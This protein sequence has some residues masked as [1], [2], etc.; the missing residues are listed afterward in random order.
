MFSLLKS[1]PINVRI[2]IP[3][4]LTIK[5]IYSTSTAIDDYH[6]F[7]FFF[8]FLCILI[9]L[10]QKDTNSIFPTISDVPFPVSKIKINYIRNS[11]KTMNIYRTF[12]CYILYFCYI[13]CY[14]Y[15]N[16]NI[17]ST[18]ESIFIGHLGYTFQ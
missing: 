6:T 14:V 10:M 8:P 15:F 7:M 4:F 17:L 9:L 16:I 3:I 18:K 1:K 2:T 5:N 11:I 13:H 12:N